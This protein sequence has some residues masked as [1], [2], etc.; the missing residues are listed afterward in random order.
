[1]L[2]Y[3]LLGFLNYAPRTGYDLEQSIEKSTGH[4]W[5]AKL[6]QIYGT[7]KKL[8][9]DELVVSHVE[10][11]E[12][13]PDRRV[14]D[15]TQ[16]GRNDLREWLSTPLTDL[17][18]TKDTL[19]LKLFFARQIGK[20]AILMQLRLQRDLHQRQAEHYREISAS[21]IRRI[22][23]EQPHL[24]EEAIFWEATRRFGELYEA[25]YVQWLDETIGNIETVISED[26]R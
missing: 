11:Q 6:S 3:A 20:E 19:L 1:M 17:E 5:H 18:P 26:D 14:Y 13:R 8:E 21:N 2:K 7:L 9:S 24:A 16:A 10:P 4:F 22:A 12:G 25:M 23:E 15:I